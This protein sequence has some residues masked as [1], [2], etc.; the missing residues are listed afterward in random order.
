MKSFRKF[1]LPPIAVGVAF[2]SLVLRAV[3]EE[4]PNIVFILVDDQRHDTLGCA[5]HPIIKTPTIDRLAE[6]GVRFE[7][8]YVNSPICMASRATLF[9]GLTETGH[10]FTGGPAPA[11][12]LQAMDVDTSVP[13]LLRKAG[14]RTGFF[15]KQH[16]RFA[17]GNDP[18]M[19]RM[20]DEYRVVNGGPHH[21]ELE[22]GTTRHTAEV[23]G[24]ESVAFLQAQP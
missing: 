23:I 7:R 4:P 14:Y 5:G 9:S 20:F 21:M 6:E 17:E 3:A 8:A 18:A 15:G 24:D 13:V 22:D 12:P 16:V 11:I 1:V 2:L 19:E 10:G